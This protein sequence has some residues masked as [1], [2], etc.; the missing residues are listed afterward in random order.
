MPLL[1]S[2]CFLLMRQIHLHKANCIMISL[3]QKTNTARG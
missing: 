2:L 1:L 3:I